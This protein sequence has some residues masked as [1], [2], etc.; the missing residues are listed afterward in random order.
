MNHP[1]LSV[2]NVACPR[3]PELKIQL[4]AEPALQHG[5]ARARSPELVVGAATRSASNV[6]DALESSSRKSTRALNHVKQERNRVGALMAALV[7][8]VK[9]LLDMLEVRACV[10]ACVR[11]LAVL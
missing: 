1:C 5:R 7:G 11:A 9:K 8:C 6:C 10:R 4:T 3:S 2:L